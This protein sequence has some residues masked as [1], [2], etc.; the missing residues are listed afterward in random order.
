MHNWGVVNSFVA[1]P[2]SLALAK[3]DWV[4]RAENHLSWFVYMSKL[5]QETTILYT[6]HIKREHSECRLARENGRHLLF[7]LISDTATIFLI[8]TE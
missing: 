4:E 5:M 8:Y 6:L 7:S 2:H 3:R 1:A